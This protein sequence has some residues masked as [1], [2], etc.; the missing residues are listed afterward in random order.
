LLNTPRLAALTAA[1][2]LA[3]LAAGGAAPAQGA[4]FAVNTTHDAADAGPGNGVCADASG[5][6][7]LRAA[8]EE[9]NA[10]PG[11]DAISV[12]AG[13]YSGALS[14][15]DSVTIDGAGAAT[16]VIRGPAPD[17]GSVFRIACSSPVLS[18]TI[19]G[20]SIASGLNE[21]GGVH[22]CGQ[23]VTLRAVI[24][25]DNSGGGSNGGAINNS[26]NLTIVDSTITGNEAREGGAI[27]NG[28]AGRVSVSNSTISQNV[29]VVGN[30]SI[31]NTSDN[32]VILENV[33]VFE[34]AAIS[35]RSAIKNTL[36]ANTGQGSNCVSTITSLG[37]NLSSD[38]SCN[39]AGPGDLNGVDPQLTGLQDNDG[40]TLTHGLYPSSPAIDAG[41]NNSCPAVDQRGVARPQGAVCDI[42]AYEYVTPST[43]PPTEPPTDAPPPPKPPTEPPTPGPTPKPKPSSSP[44]PSATSNPSAT[45]ARTQ[46]PTAGAA[47]LVDVPREVPGVEEDAGGGIS[48][49]AAGLAT[50]GALGLAGSAASAG[51]FWHRRRRN[52]LR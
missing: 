27:V 24:L 10:L 14:I 48:A 15:S 22:N 25:R 3:A 11:A 35:G 49:M 20:L 34:T 30:G 45:A 50:A 8:V 19:T 4:S 6:C 12:P 37:H 39:L 9:T 26:G 44:S 47:V 13:E 28:D 41:D 42:G 23:S 7:T 1:I 46:R 31:R 40:P 18:I 52:R 5:A 21:G 36:I 43:A 32:P 16:T 29:S 17:L 38:N 33:T 51:F 2:A